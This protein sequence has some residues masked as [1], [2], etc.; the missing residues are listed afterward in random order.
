MA[1]NVTV[2]GKAGPGLTLTAAVFT[3]VMNFTISTGSANNS[4]QMLILAF[5][6]GR[7]IQYVAIGAATTFTV[8]LTAGTFAVTIS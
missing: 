8:V 4:A 1:A 7:P 5:A 3:N 6:D 2:T